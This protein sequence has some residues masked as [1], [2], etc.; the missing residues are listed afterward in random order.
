MGEESEYQSRTI[1]NGCAHKWFYQ[2]GNK[3][4]SKP[5]NITLKQ[6]DRE[7]TMYQLIVAGRYIN[8]VTGKVS[9]L[10]E[11]KS[12]LHSSILT[13]GDHVT[14]EIECMRKALKECL[15]RYGGNEWDWQESE[16]LISQWVKYVE[17]PAHKKN[18]LQATSE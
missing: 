8:K 7:E 15:N 11:T 17:S 4:V 14:F 16:I 9:A 3:Q 5:T 13:M 1:E 6:W 18:M 2:Y 12:E 10:I